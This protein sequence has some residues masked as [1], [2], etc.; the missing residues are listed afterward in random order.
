[1]NGMALITQ[2]SHVWA[3]KIIH[4]AG[5]LR[6]KDWI[7]TFSAYLGYPSQMGVTI[8]L[9]SSMVKSKGSQSKTLV[10]KVS[11]KTRN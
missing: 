2:V 6:V 3:L 11:I 8:T 4:L 5:V 10:R 1:M 7:V 9:P